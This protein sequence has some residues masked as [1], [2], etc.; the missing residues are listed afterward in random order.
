VLNT[1][2]DNAATV[3]QATLLATGWTPTVVWEASTGQPKAATTP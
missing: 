3:M 2:K 1:A